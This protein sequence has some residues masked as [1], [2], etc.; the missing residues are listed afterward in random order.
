VSVGSGPALGFYHA[1]DYWGVPISGQGGDQGR[2][3]AIELKQ[4]SKPYGLSQPTCSKVSVAEAP[5][6]GKL[7]LVIMMSSLLSVEIFGGPY[8]A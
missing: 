2:G 6:L 4:A 3:V 1:S 8:P 5:E 7:G